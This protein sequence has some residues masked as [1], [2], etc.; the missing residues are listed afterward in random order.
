MTPPMMTSSTYAESAIASDVVHMLWTA[1]MAPA[2]GDDSSVCP[3]RVSSGL[4]ASRARAA[5][6]EVIALPISQ[7]TSR[8]P[9]LVPLLLPVAGA[10]NR[11]GPGL[12]GEGGEDGCAASS[13]GVLNAAGRAG[14]CGGK[15]ARGATAPA[16]RMPPARVPARTP[17]PGPAAPRGGPGG[18]GGGAAAGPGGR[19]RGAGGGGGGGVTGGPGTWGGGGGRAQGPQGRSRG[20]RGATRFGRAPPGGG[21]RRPSGPAARRW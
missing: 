3:A 12:A 2:C 18:P 7:P 13:T 19:G 11:P 15:A 20:G 9:Q 16:A 14:R 21:P 5:N 4:S 10:A 1:G 8:N 6:H 17:P